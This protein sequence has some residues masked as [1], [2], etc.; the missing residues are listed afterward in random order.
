MTH[1]AQT[2]PLGHNSDGRRHSVAEATGAAADP[3]GREQHHSL[4]DPSVQEEG[5]TPTAS[6]SHARLEHW[7][8]QVALLMVCEFLRYRPVNAGYGTRLGY[9]TELVMAAGE[10]ST[11]SH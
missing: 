11:P 7:N 2:P 5:H 9:I 4:F 6:S 10:D 3:I 8:V 1:V